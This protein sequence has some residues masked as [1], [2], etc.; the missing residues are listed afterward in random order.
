[1]GVAYVELTASNQVV[2]EQVATERGLAHKGAGVQ[3]DLKFAQK[4]VTRLLHK[5]RT[6]FYMYWSPL[7]NIY[8]LTPLLFNMY[9]LNPLLF[10]IY[11]WNPQ[12]SLLGASEAR[13][14][15]QTESFVASLNGANE[16]LLGQV[17][18]VHVYYVYSIFVYQM[19]QTP[20]IHITLLLHIVWKP[21]IPPM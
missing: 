6:V 7:F 19:Q 17:R 21:L 14:L 3:R 12:V 8:V 13:R 9:A 15:A 16:A 18:N 11:V 2:G 4:D 10:N 20:F 5:V 1:V